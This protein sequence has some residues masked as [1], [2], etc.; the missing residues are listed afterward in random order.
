MDVNE[1]AYFL[2]ERGVLE[3]IAGKPRSYRFGSTKKY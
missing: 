1:D 2:N 3:S